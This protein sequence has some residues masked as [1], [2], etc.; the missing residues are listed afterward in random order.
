[1]S[2]AAA[3]E[4]ERNEGMELQR[5]AFRVQQ[6]HPSRCLYRWP[7]V[8]MV[9]GGEQHLGMYGINPSF[10][11]D[12]DGLGMSGASTDPRMSQ[13]T[14]AST[15]NGCLVWRPVSMLGYARV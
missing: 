11:H 3:P 7:Q 5:D 6:L 15:S 1:M 9:W 14:I 12:V 10:W 4:Q 2:V 8:G 13:S